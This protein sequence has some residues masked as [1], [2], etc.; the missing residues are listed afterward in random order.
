MTRL[1]GEFAQSGNL[2]LCG[3]NAQRGLRECGIVNDTCDHHKLSCQW[4]IHDVLTETNKLLAMERLGHK[5]SPH[6][7]SWAVFNADMALFLLISDKE[8]SNV[9]VPGPLSG[10]FPAVRFK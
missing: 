3:A 6:G 8:V 9:E 5:I 10:T 2:H 4:W 7:I 1:T